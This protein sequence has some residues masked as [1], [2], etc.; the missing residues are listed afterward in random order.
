LLAAWDQRR[1]WASNQCLSAGQRLSNDTVCSP[2]STRRELRR[3]RKLASMPHTA[4]ALRGGTLSMDLFDVLGRANSG[5]RRALFA[6]HEPALVQSLF[7]LRY[8]DAV[9]VIEYWIA[10][11]D[12][13][14]GEPDP[15]QEAPTVFLSQVG[16][17]W[18]LNGD[19]DAI[20]GT[21]VDDELKRLARELREADDRVGIRRSRAER[22]AA[23]LVQMAQ[24]SA[25]ASGPAAKLRPLFTVHV[26]DGTLA[27]LCELANGTVIRPAQLAPWID[28]ALMEVVL[29]DGP[30]TV[31]SVSHRRTF[32]GALR[33][34][35]QARDRHCQ[36]TSGCDRPADECD[37]DH[38]EPS[39]L[40]GPTSQFN[41]R[42]ECTPHNRLAALHDAGEPPLPV[43]QVDFLRVFRCRAKWRVRH[44]PPDHEP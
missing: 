25:S 34:A 1:V 40:G 24:R 6:E 28:A 5:R 22:R 8:L 35:I 16:D 31:L 26:G 44:E 27:Q 9:R 10:K 23:A 30:A 18:A 42:L 4:A 37:V 20:G 7:G 41:G 14:V 13:E 43:S 2:H 11:A 39:S 29:F 15:A 36:H 3:A 17:R 12:A 33:R 38:I 32:T 19:L 21:V